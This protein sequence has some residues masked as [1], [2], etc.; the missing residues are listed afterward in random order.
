MCDKWLPL[1]SFSL[2]FLIP[3]GPARCFGATRW[4]KF[5]CWDTGGKE[6]DIGMCWWISTF[7]LSTLHFQSFKNPVAVDQMFLLLLRDAVLAALGYWLD[8]AYF[9]TLNPQFSPPSIVS[10]PVTPPKSFISMCWWSD[11]Y[12]FWGGGDTL[13]L[14]CR[15]PWMYLNHLAAT[16]FLLC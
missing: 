13:E 10:S 15:V 12:V 4:S 7:S 9:S 14:V 8:I 16:I 11:G 2:Q 6:V 5:S 1:C 3:S